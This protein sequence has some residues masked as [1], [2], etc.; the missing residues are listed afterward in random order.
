MIVYHGMNGL[1]ID[2]AWVSTETYD[3]WFDFFKGSFKVIL[4]FQWLPVFLFD[5]LIDH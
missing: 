3:T 2:Y 1:F 5:Y 4:R